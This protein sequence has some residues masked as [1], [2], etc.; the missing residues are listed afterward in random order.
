MMPFIGAYNF[1][2]LSCVSINAT[3]A[4]ADLIAEA[5]LFYLAFETFNDDSEALNCACAASSA[6]LT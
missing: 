6:L 1:V 3:C 2:F 4:S 5:E